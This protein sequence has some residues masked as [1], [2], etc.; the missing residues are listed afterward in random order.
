MAKTKHLPC[1]F[2]GGAGE[3]T[4]Y[5][6]VNVR[7]RV[8]CSNCGATPAS[9]FHDTKAA[10]WERWDMRSGIGKCSGCGNY[11]ISDKASWCTLTARLREPGDYCSRWE[12][13]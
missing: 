7:Y 13:A 11:T 8:Q 4:E 5:N 10:A 1:P 12:K 9:Y 2:C 6:S 3:M